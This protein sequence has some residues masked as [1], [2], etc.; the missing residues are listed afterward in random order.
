MRRII[1]YFIKYYPELFSSPAE[2][3]E[4]ILCVLGNGIKI[5]TDGYIDY[6]EDWGDILDDIKKIKL[7]ELDPV[8]LK[9]I[10]PYIDVNKPYSNIFKFKNCK[11]IELKEWLNYFIKCIEITDNNVT[12]ITDWKNNIN[13]IKEEF[14]I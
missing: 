10:Y 4:M 7:K 3:L 1:S 5:G 14:D 6:V 9:H 13:K 12:Y 2:V 8:P 11:E